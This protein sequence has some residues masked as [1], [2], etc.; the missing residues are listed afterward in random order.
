MRK[1]LIRLPYHLSKNRQ[2]VTK[3]QLN[4]QSTNIG[5]F[6]MRTPFK[7]YNCDMDGREGVLKNLSDADSERL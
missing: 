7:R 4:Y 2:K 1:K 3:K 6:D 5:R